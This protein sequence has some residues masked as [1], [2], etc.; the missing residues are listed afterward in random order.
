MET[1]KT[2]A[3]KL[4]DPRWQKKRLEIF[5]RDKFC[6]LI[7]SSD[8]DMLQ[9]HHER[10]CKNPW[11]S[12]DQDLKTLCFRCHEVVE[13]CKTQGYKYTNINRMSGTDGTFFYLVNSEYEGVNRVSVIH[14]KNG[15][16]E[17]AGI[18]LSKE[19]VQTLLNTF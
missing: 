1:K 15:E 11:E 13:I 6:C 12:P 5:S 17:D 19:F 2:Y 18:L 10:Y 8:R 14:N 16:F 9:V 7:C 4:Q 3:K